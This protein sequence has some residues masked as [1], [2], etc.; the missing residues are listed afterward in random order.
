MSQSLMSRDKSEAM[1]KGLF[2]VSAWAGAGAAGFLPRP[3]SRTAGW[4]RG[5]VLD[6]PLVHVPR[7]ARNA[8]LVSSRGRAKVPPRAAMAA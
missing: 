8:F 3:I 4:R 7:Q 2:A 1:K 6:V 5:G